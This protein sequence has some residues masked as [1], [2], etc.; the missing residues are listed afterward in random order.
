MD[1]YSR[2][3]FNFNIILYVVS[4]DN[5]FSSAF[6]Q[7]MH[8]E[9]S[10]QHAAALI[11]RGSVDTSLPNSPTASPGH[12]VPCPTHTLIIILHGGSIL[13]SGTELLS[14][15]KSDMTTFRGAFESVM[16]QHYSSLIGRIAFRFVPCPP[17]CSDSLMVLSNLSPY[18]FQASPSAIDGVYHTYDAIPLGALPLF[19]ISSHEYHENVSRVISLTNQ[20]YHEFLKSEEGIGFCGQVTLIGDSIGSLM[21]FD[22]LCRASHSCTSQ[23]GSESSIP[24]MPEHH[25]VQN[26][27][28]EMSTQPPHSKTTISNRQNPLISISDGSGNSGEDADDNVKDA[29]CE[30]KHAIRCNRQN[31]A[32]HKSVRKPPTHPNDPTPGTEECIPSC[33][34]LLIAPASRRRSSGSS[35][36][37]CSHK[38]EFDVYDFFMFGSPLG[39]V[40]TFR[41]MLSFD[42]KT[43][44]F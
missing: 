40:L 20:A 15:K 35:D 4:A 8:V 39:L 26:K 42:D 44:E 16:R 2:L 27:T 11:G 21:A 38:F 33:H 19:A 31:S 7:R 34:R 22:A 1:N 3:T 24:D 17:I 18:S 32:H 37:S 14:N 28:A 30:S 5:I 12:H 13:D 29:S 36:Q 25:H 41:K 9:H 10:R 6:I 23:Y 43:C